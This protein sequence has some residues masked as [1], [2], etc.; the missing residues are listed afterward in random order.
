MSSD[1]LASVPVFP[2][3]RRGYDPD[4]V[5]HYVQV[6][7]V[8]LGDVNARLAEA[9]DRLRT[10]A[11][12]IGPEKSESAAVLRA[13]KAAGHKGPVRGSRAGHPHRRG[14]R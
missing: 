1:P 6:L 13:A 3:R 14:G 8:Q 7:Q 12:D 9:E 11:M 2:E 4:V 10:A 5:D